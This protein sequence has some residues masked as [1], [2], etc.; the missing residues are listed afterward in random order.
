MANVNFLKTRLINIAFNR[1]YKT[2]KSVFC[3]TGLFHA[4]CLRVKVKQS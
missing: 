1:N 2:L 4:A 3:L